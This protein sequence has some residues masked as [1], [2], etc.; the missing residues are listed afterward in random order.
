MCF[1]IAVVED[2]GIDDV[3]YRGGS[4]FSNLGFGLLASPAVIGPA[5]LGIIS[6]PPQWFQWDRD[7]SVA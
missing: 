7:F 4:H 3:V 2:G 6:S 5:F 1:I